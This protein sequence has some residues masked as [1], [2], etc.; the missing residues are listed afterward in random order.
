MFSIERWQEIFEGLYKNKLRTALTGVSVASG[1]FILVILLGAGNGIQNGIQK[2]FEQDAVNRVSVW[3]GVTQK[4]YNGLGVGRSVQLHNADYDLATTLLKDYIEYKSAI[5]SVWSGNIV[6]KKETGTYRVEGVHP[7]YQF[8]ENASIVK[9]RFVNQSD[10]ANYEKNV[11][12]GQKVANDLFKNGED[13]LGEQLNVSGMIYKV[14]GVYS[15]PGGEREESRVFIPIA[16]AQK[17]YSAGDSIRSMAFTLKKSDQFDNAVAE[18][19]EFTQKLETFL[20]ARHTIAPDDQ[21]AL[22]INNSLEQAKNIYIITGGVQ[23]FFWFVGICTIIAGVVGV[24]NIMLIIV[25]ERTKEI[26]IRKALGAS[27]ISIITMILQEA[28]FITVIAGFSGLIFGLI[29]WEIVGPYVEADFFTRP[30]VDF[31]V[32]VTTLVILIVAGAFAGFVPAYR[33]AKIRPIVALRGE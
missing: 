11:I 2:Q 10:N 21:G 1:I 23:A 19:H 30:E 4:E 9:G 3:P 20:K 6:Y 24:G 25:K 33:A 17:A 5:F 26:G 15:D 13:P 29:V 31:N 8:I 32:A 18:S 7:D 12:I 28:V 16:T 22:Y 14:V 27:P